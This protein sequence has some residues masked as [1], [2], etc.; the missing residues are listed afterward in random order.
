LAARDV[1]V[2]SLILA[3]ADGKSY[4][5][6]EGELNS[7]RPTIVRWKSPFEKKWMAGLDAEHKGRKPATV[8]RR[9]RFG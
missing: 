9:Y 1:F 3:F 6:I 4:T 8:N 2:A 5:E 7:S